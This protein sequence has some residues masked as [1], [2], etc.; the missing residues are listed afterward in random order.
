MLTFVV[1]KWVFKNIC[2][3]NC[4]QIKYI[5]CAFEAEDD[6]DKGLLNKVSEEV[7]DVKLSIQ[8]VH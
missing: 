7:A 5:I 1:D 6:Q 3:T 8:N 2:L 4:E